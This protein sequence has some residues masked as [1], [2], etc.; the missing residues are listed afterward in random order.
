MP[1]RLGD[2]VVIH[3]RLRAGGRDIVDT[4]AAAPE[5]F[6]L[7]H[8]DLDP[9]I[10][11]L[12]RDLAVGERRVFQLDP[13]QAFGCRDETLLQTLPRS[14]LNLG[15]PPVPGHGV[16]FPLPNGETLIG[17]IVATAADT[18]TV[19]FNHPLA[20]LAVELTLE[21]LDLRKG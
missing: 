4:F 17:T 7:G 6:T 13:D 12:L 21:L 8:G 2:T 20:G 11:T 18:V 14:E 15:E 1:A 10:E 16:E 9:R 19:D 5:T 3:Y